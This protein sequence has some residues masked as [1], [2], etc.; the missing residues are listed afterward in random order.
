V[1]DELKGVYMHPKTTNIPKNRHKNKLP[2]FVDQHGGG[3]CMCDKG[4][5]G[6]KSVDETCIIVTAESTRVAME[7]KSDLN[8]V[9]LLEIPL[10]L[11]SI[12]ILLQELLTNQIFPR[13][14]VQVQ[15]A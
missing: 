13:F 12:S 6:V 9:F 1:G 14:A 15:S 10:K 7:A 3:Y 11:P 2:V 8:L 5:L 4:T